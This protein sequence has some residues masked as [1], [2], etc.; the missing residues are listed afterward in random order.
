MLDIAWDR[1]EDFLSEYQEICIMIAGIIVIIILISIFISFRMKMRNQERIL[2]KAQIQEERY[3]I[4]AEISN[5]ILFEYDIFSDQMVYSDKYTENFG[6]KATI[7]R[8]AE[9]KE[10]VQYVYKEDVFAFENFCKL[11]G[12]E[13]Q[14][15]EAEYRM[16]RSSGDYVWCYVCGQTIYDSMNNPVKVVGKLSNIDIQKREVEKLQ[17]KAEM[18]A[19]TRIYNKV[20]TKE[21][22]NN[23]IK[24]S[25]NQ[26]K[27]ALLIVDMDN[28]KKI[29]DTFGHLKGDEVL[30]EGVGHLKNMFRGDDIIG[31]IG[32]DEFVVFMSNVTSRE[33]IV[34][35]AKSIGKAFRKTYSEDGEEV[36]VSASI[37]IS[38]FPMDGD[39]YEELL[40]KSDKALYEVKKN[41]KNGFCFYH[42]QKA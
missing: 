40:D 6:R 11:L 39:D 37:G 36:T 34:N 41:G 30:K 1:L 25:R 7:E 18:D 14:K 42:E 17:F 32:G 16:K 21:R 26:D 19:M 2:Q 38:I 24:N 8:F 10:E 23:F 13:K 5:D 27:H 31:R 22:I 28:F 33:D 9:L 29:N 15:L 20:A 3:R 35:K 4:L 12:G